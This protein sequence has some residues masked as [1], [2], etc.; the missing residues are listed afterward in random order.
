MKEIKRPTL[1]IN[2][3]IAKANIKAMAQKAK[4][5]NLSF[6]PHFKT[7]QSK[8]V[9]EWFREEGVTA[10]TVSSVAMAIYFA[11]NGWENITI[12]FPVNVLELEEIE[13]LASKVKLTLL[14]Q[15]TLV[16]KKLNTLTSKVYLFIEVDAGY[17]RSGININSKQEIQK[18]IKTI[19][20]T[21]HRFKGFYYHAGNSYNARSTK[22][23]LALYADMS[24]KLAFLK[25]EFNDYNPHI[26]TGD[27]PCCS[28]VDV[29]EGIDSIHP[30][31]FVYYDYTQMAI[32]ACTINQVAI[33]VSCPVV[34]TYL[35]RNEWVIYGGGVHLSKESL[36]TEIGKIAGL[37]GS[38]DEN[39]DFSA[40]PDVYVKS[41]SQEHGTIASS[42]PLPSSINV[43][44]VVYILPIHSC[45]TVDCMPNAFTTTGALISKM[46][47]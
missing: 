12:A 45:M 44:D 24:S 32:G 4:I 20:T 38:L 29:F 1:F 7:H 9:G 26:A 18:I 8:E 25:Q 43:G 47:K 16:V 19:K 35:D 21:K 34:A 39:G 42:L 10:I 40:F 31:N 22:D 46:K 30:G 37:V 5:N 13:Q 36:I 23:V 28:V 27:T 2:K 33:Y 14:V 41:L 6:E 17:H 3:A 15:D 11:A